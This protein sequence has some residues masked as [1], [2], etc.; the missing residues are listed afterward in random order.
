MSDLEVQNLSK[1][2]GT[3]TVVDN[4]SFQVREGEFF[5]LL[6]PSGGGKSTI[7]RIISGLET[8]DAGRI[9]LGDQDITNLTPRQR[10]LGMVFQ[11]YGLYPS[12]NVFSN[13]SYGLEARGM[14]RQEIDKRVRHAA[15]LLELTPHLQRSINM[16]SGGEQQRVALARILAKDAE[17]FLFDEP[18]S[19]LDPKLR[20]QAR[21]DIIKVHREK[22]KPSIYVTH[23]QSE[24]FAAADRIAVIAKG[25]LQQIGTPD[26]MLN[27][28]TNVFMAQ[29]IG[30]PP[31]NVLPG[32]PFYKDNGYIIHF[33]S[34]DIPLPAKWN[35]VLQSYPQQ[36]VLL[37]I[38]PNAIIPQWEWNNLDEKPYELTAEVLDIE[39]LIGEM[40]MTLKLG[41]DIIVK[42]L[43]TE[44][45]Q[46]LPQVGTR[47]KIGINSEALRLFDP[48]TEQLIKAE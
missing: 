46:E 18:L 1:K 45:E 9:V 24:A 22:R 5:V 3:N 34:I 40:I 37:G 36:T 41:D 28:P 4:V 48:Q 13:I 29:F 14:A 12:M 33:D 27:Q 43:V 21:R 2:F 39:E 20:F 44:P 17:L 31:M 32:Q 30:T 19:N 15:E 42:A 8:P 10:N 38:P 47:L 25:H 7:L 26:E 16:L 23:D 35:R 11:D 6:G